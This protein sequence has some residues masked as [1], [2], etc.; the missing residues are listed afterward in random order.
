MA[1]TEK[2]ALEEGI[3]GIW[4]ITEKVN[5]L[6][7]K[8]HFSDAERIEFEKISSEK[9]Q[10]EYL[11]VRL[12]VQKL[13]NAKTEILYDNSGKPS[14]KNSD[15]NL[16]ISHS[17]NLAVVFLSKRK[18]GIDVENVKRNIE[19]VANRFLNDSEKEFVRINR[20]PQKAKILIWCAKE[21]VFKCSENQGID[22]IKEIIISLFSADNEKVFEGKLIQSGK[23]TYYQLQHFI[24]KNNVVVFCVEE[25][26]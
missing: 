19:N 7:S 18:I 2:I 4:E 5:S 9:R 13:M 15:L 23:T 20:N 11:T 25:V 12:L 16:S 24:Y 21:A 22:F 14:L 17:N 6:R 10:R 1:F 26:E 3:I 8:F